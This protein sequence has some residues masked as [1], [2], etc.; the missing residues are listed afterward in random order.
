[1]TSSSVAADAAAEAIS[2]EA[3]CDRPVSTP[4]FGWLEF[5]AY[6]KKAK[7]TRGLTKMFHL[8]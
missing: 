4:T 7:M 8:C 5:T 1:V 2:Q 3:Q 6:Q